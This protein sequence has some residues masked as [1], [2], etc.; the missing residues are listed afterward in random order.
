MRSPSARAKDKATKLHSQIVRARGRC[1]N[2]GVS[3]DTLQCAHIVSRRYA[4]TRTDLDNAFCL[5]ARCHMFF[6]EWSVPWV[7]FIDEQ[8]GRDAYEALE[9]KAN[10]GVGKKVDWAEEVERLAALWK[11]TNV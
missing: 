4:T 2:C 5:C 8:I 10:E 11:L 3:N 7:E 6:T 9:R 1:E